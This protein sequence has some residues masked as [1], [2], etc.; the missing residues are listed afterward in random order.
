V[1]K[2]LRRCLV[3]DR[4]LRLQAIGEGRILL[5]GPE[6]SAAAPDA[7]IEQ[8][9]PSRSRLSAWGWVAAGIFGAGLAALAFVHFREPKEDLRPVRFSV[10]PPQGATGSSF[11]QV[12]PDGHRLAF[13]AT[14]QGKTS[15]WIR[16]LDSLAARPLPGA[17]A[18]NSRS[19]PRIAV[20]W[21]L[22]LT[23]NSKRSTSPAAP[24]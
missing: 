6:E 10:L 24:R 12:S 21:G 13:Q 3:K 17:M 15:L 16:D 18:D 22:W 8:T 4:K 1:E 7:P 9:A 11:M 23:G 19:G 20:P 5:A 14:I 2:L